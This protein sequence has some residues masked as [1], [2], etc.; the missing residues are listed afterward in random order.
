MKTNS[1]TFY[2]NLSAWQII[3]RRVLFFTLLSPFILLIA[4]GGLIFIGVLHDNRNHRHGT[5]G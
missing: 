5:Y 2:D 1:Y 3:T 4:V